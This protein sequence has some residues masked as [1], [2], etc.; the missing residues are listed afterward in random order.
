MNGRTGPF[1]GG[2]HA[3]PKREVKQPKRKDFGKLKI[4]AGIASSL[5]SLGCFGYALEVKASK[6]KDMPVIT[7]GDSL[8]RGPAY[9]DH[10]KI[11]DGRITTAWATESGHIYISDKIHAGSE[12]AKSYETLFDYTKYKHG[13]PYAECLVA[14]GTSWA[15]AGVVVSKGHNDTPPIEQWSGKPPTATLTV[16]DSGWQKPVTVAAQGYGI[17]SPTGK[18]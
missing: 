2:I 7:I 9:Y 8:T 4:C 5:I 17:S 1:P 16:G 3:R 10:P 14:T 11:K 6:E 15:E 12:P 13:A 18:K